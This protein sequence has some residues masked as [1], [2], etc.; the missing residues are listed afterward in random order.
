M[1]AAPLRLVA[2]QGRGG[3]YDRGMAGLDCLVLL[4]D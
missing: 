1:A 4:F 2:R 3:L